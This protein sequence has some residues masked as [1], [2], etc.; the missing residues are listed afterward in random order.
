MQVFLVLDDDHALRCR[1]IPCRLL[2]D[3]DARDHV[4][5]L[6]LTGFSVM[7]GTL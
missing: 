4:A 6:D 5:E 1:W 2:G 3:R 7:I